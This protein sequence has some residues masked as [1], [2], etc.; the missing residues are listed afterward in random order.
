MT[1]AWID[2]A[3]WASVMYNQDLKFELNGIYHFREAMHAQLIYI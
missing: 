1:A 2:R 3:E